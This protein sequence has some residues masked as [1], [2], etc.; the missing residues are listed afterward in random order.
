MIKYFLLIK[1]EK[2]IPRPASYSAAFSLNLHHKFH[3]W[4]TFRAQKFQL[5]T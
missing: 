3:T 5:F 4:S 2:T 1:T